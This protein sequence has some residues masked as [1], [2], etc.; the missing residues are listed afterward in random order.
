MERARHPVAGVARCSA[1]L[2]FRGGEA[3]PATTL[4]S[5]HWRADET[6]RLQHAEQLA[7]PERLAA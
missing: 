2:Y 7:V 1:A 6:E 4:M 5:D 3:A